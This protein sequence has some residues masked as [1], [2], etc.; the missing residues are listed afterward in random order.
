MLTG[1]EE[2]RQRVLGALQRYPELNVKTFEH[3]RELWV[4]EPTFAHALAEGIVPADAP[5]RKALVQRIGK[6]L[7]TAQGQEIRFGWYGFDDKIYL[8]ARMEAMQV[9]IDNG[10]TAEVLQQTNNPWE[11]PPSGMRPD[12][13][14]VKVIV[15]QLFKQGGSEPVVSFRPMFFSSRPTGVAQFPLY[16]TDVLYSFGQN[17]SGQNQLL[18]DQTFV[19]HVGRAYKTNPA[20]SA[21]AEWRGTNKLPSGVVAI[22]TGGHISHDKTGAPVLEVIDTPDK[23]RDVEKA[24]TAA[25]MVGGIFA[26]GLTLVGAGS[27]IVSGRC[28][29]LSPRGRHRMGGARRSPHPW[30]VQLI[31][32]PGRA[33]I[34]IE[35]GRECGGP[36]HVCQRSGLEK[37]AVLRPADPRSGPGPQPGECDGGWHGYRGLRERGRSPDKALQ[38]DVARRHWPCPF[39][40]GLAGPDVGSRHPS[41]W[42]IGR[43]FQ[44]NG[45]RTDA[46][47][48]TPPAA[49]RP[50]RKHRG[51]RRLE[52]DITFTGMLA[53]WVG[54]RSGTERGSIVAD[55]SKL[56]SWIAQQTLKLESSVLEPREREGILNDIAV[57]VQRRDK[58]IERLQD[59]RNRPDADRGDQPIL[60]PDSTRGRSQ[61]VH[62]IRTPGHDL[63][64]AFRRI[65]RHE[66]D[67]A[68]RETG[69]DEINDPERIIDWCVKNQKF[70]KRSLLDR[71]LGLPDYDKAWQQFLTA[72]VAT[73]S[74]EE[75]EPGQ[76]GWIRFSPEARLV[77]TLS[78]IDPKALTRAKKKVG[79]ENAGVI[80]DWFVKNEG[81]GT[82]KA[83]ERAWQ[84]YLSRLAKERQ[85]QQ[86]QQ[87][88]VAPFLPQPAVAPIPHDPGASAPPAVAPIPDERRA[89][90]PSEADLPEPTVTQAAHP[91]FVGTDVRG[92]VIGGGA[93]LEAQADNEPLRVGDFLAL[94]GRYANQDFGLVKGADIARTMAGLSTNN[95]NGNAVSSGQLRDDNRL[96]VSYLLSLLQ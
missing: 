6:I 4:I 83:Y 21:F 15:D 56:D 26:G 70:A 75:P 46:D 18:P 62:Y 81:L 33:C 49:A 96:D 80:I 35:P 11:N 24:V 5:D 74:G 89:S 77:M 68:M 13:S 60:L 50:L 61:A 38:R 52:G 90:A 59:L 54:A 92:H 1:T 29:V 7:A 57:C 65:D 27:W 28:G 76:Y 91:I 67:R 93:S 51:S 86:Q 95:S 12:H 55:I 9:I 23:G 82:K 25:M 17:R 40:I 88:V 63:V 30:P 58:L 66:F 48:A 94:V 3:H 42:R 32:E 34:E 78:E 47:S 37:Y 41:S 84:N 43:H 8:A 53:R 79:S 16:R 36:G 20:N 85:G 2:R 14:N 10:I 64:D 22:P 87:P 39:A 72:R 71:T 31:L 73:Q 45:R 69:A 19:D 44:S